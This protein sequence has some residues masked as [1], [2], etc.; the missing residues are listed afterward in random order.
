M[1]NIAWNTIVIFSF[2]FVQM[3]APMVYNTNPI[4]TGGNSGA[5]EWLAVLAPLV[6]PVVLI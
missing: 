2:K 3:K 4:K 1:L 6:A 5:P